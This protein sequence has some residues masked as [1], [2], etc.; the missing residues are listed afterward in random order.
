MRRILTGG[1]GVAVVAVIAVVIFVGAS[2]R[3]SPDWIQFSIAPASGE[4]ASI[5][6][7]SIRANGMTLKAAIATA[8]DMPAVRIVGPP[9]LLDTRYSVT[10]ELGTDAVARFR[11]LL[12]Q[13]LTKRLRLETHFEARPYE[14]FVLTAPES[15][16]LERSTGAGPSTWISKHDVR[17]RGVSMQDVASALQGI[18]GR[19]VIDETGIRGSY[20]MEFEWVGERFASVTA[21]LRDRFGL[22]L[23]PATRNMETLVVDRIRRDPALVF[24]DQVGRITRA[25]PAPIRRGIADVLTT[26]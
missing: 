24:F 26:R 20:D 7:A 23:S 22:R 9:S 10:A 16:R 18:L 25:A 15:A 8:Y 4:S 6:P 5:G 21:T 2:R 17:M 13:E 19:P 14:V 12:Q 11:P 1:V 3:A